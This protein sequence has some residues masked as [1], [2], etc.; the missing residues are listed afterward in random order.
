M[1]SECQLNIINQW[2]EQTINL[3]RNWRES[4]KEEERLKE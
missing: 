2:Y 3:N 4:K 1:E